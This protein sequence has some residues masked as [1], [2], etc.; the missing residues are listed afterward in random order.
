MSRKMYIG[1]GIALLIVGFVALQIYLNTGMQQVRKQID[2]S[3]KETKTEPSSD[4]RVEPEQGQMPKVD[5]RPPMPD[6]GQEYVWHGDHWCPKEV[7]NEIIM[8]SSQKTEDKDSN[9]DEFGI[10]HSSEELALSPE[11][12]RQLYLDDKAVVDAKIAAHKAETEKLHAKNLAKYELTQKINAKVKH[13]GE[14]IYPQIRELEK[15]IDEK[16]GIRKDDSFE[17]REQTIDNLSRQERK[18]LLNLNQQITKLNKQVLQLFDEIKVL[19]E[20]Y[21]N[22]DK[23]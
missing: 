4:S 1:I 10:W 2:I 21:D 6:D 8:L 11:E 7:I 13:Y 17:T 12:R 20:E 9:V 16:F 14:V 5:D 23:K 18:I 15:T 19:R 22:V 3:S